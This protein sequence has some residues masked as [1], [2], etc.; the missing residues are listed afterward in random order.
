MVSDEI[1]ADLIMPGHTF[2]STGA[3]FEEYEKILVVNAPSKTFNIAGLHT[4]NVFVFDPKLRRA[5]KKTMRKNFLGTP[6]V[7]ALLACKSAYEKCDDWVDAQNAHIQSN[8]ELVKSFMAEN[9]PEAR[10]TTLEGTYLLWIDL[11]AFGVSGEQIYQGLMAQGVVV[12]E[13]KKYKPQCDGFIRLNVAC[14]KEQLLEGLRRMDTY[15]EAL[16]A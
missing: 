11:R 6:N 8:Y 14:S 4:A 5:L 10:V 16:R 12:G 13:G 2:V 3:F 1:H 15:F 9:I 7:L